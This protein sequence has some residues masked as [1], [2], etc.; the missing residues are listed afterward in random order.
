[1]FWVARSRL[2][3]KR[4]IPWSIS[5]SPDGSLLAVGF[6]A[7]VAIYDPPS[8]ALIRT[9]TTAELRGPIRSV[10]FLGH[11]GRF[12]AVAGRSDVVLWDLV[13]QKGKL[14]MVSHSVICSKSLTYLVQWHHRSAHPISAVISH[15]RD[16]D[17]AVFTS[18][19]P[20]STVSIF[21]SS[22]SS[23]RNTYT[24]PFSLRNIVWYPQSSSKAKET[25]AFRLV[26]IT[27][28]WDVVVCGDDVHPL[29]EEGSVARGLLTSSQAPSRRTLFQDIWGDSA[30]TG[31]LVD[32]LVQKKVASTAPRNG[33]EITDIFGG[34][35]Y[36][37]PP[38]ETLFEPIMTHFLT[39][40]PPEDETIRVPGLPG[41]DAEDTNMDVDESHDDVR[42]SGTRAERV[43]DARE[44]DALIHLFRQH[45]VKGMCHRT[46]FDEWT[47]LTGVTRTVAH[48]PGPSLKRP[49]PR[50]SK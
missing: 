8:N 25:S 42:V 3:F 29:A 16:E 50:D 49:C 19:P 27:D 34:P 5:W 22:K 23:P 17:L 15:P 35:A 24:L 45:G 31:A 47:C 7:Y 32:P 10:H 2:T 38:L 39:P 40:R 28:R 33:Q 12:L 20:S 37:I 1:M 36:M 44:M 18:R 30:L 26:G 43:V 46:G 14:L 48:F 4:E 11:E 9:F 21:E 41:E 6:G 13:T